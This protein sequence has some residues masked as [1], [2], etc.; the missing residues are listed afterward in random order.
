M[1]FLP[2]AT[3]VTS[4]VISPM[5]SPRRSSFT[6]MAYEFIDTIIFGDN[7]QAQKDLLLVWPI[8]KI[9][10]SLPCFLQSKYKDS[11]ERT[12]DNV[13]PE[14]RSN[15][16]RFIIL[17]YTSG[18]IPVTTK[19]PE[20]IA[21]LTE[22]IKLLNKEPQDAINP[23]KI[24]LISTTSEPKI[25]PG[26]S[27]DGMD[28]ILGINTISDKNKTTF[29]SPIKVAQE[30]TRQCAVIYN[31]ITAHEFATI[32]FEDQKT[33][34]CIHYT[35]LV[36]LFNTI[37]NWTT[38]TIL[39][40]NNDKTTI[41][42]EFINLT[43]EFAKLN[44]FHLTMAVIA[45]LNSS[46]I[47]RIPFLKAPRPA[48]ERYDK[49]YA[50]F[51]HNR[52]YAKYR[53]ILERVTNKSQVIPYMGVI[54]KDLLA[55]TS[56]E[57][58]YNV[59]KKEVNKITYDALIK[60]SKDYLVV[61]KYDI[62]K[63]MAVCAYLDNQQIETDENILYDLSLAIFPISHQESTQVID[64]LLKSNT[65]D[66]TKS[67]PSRRRSD[68]DLSGSD[69]IFRQ[70][71]LMASSASIVCLTQTTPAKP[72]IPANLTLPI[73]DT[74]KLITQASPNKIQ[75]KKISQWT[76][77]DTVKW[78]N[79]I[80]FGEHSSKFEKHKITGNILC[81]LTREDLADIG[82]NTVGDRLRFLQ[83]VRK[84]IKQEQD[85]KSKQH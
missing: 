9:P 74:R 61:K 66:W 43:E 2:T 84:L 27:L 17:A 40:T 14:L 45:G 4:P 22:F 73:L 35:K 1:T 34:K 78:L 10:K 50:D 52:N 80:S 25:T 48:I 67:T 11:K 64:E 72:L 79:I 12:D 59:E 69:K 31:K 32:G 13:T 26:K 24:L 21:Q 83:E 77:C 55:Y 5:I 56:K 53:E 70:S 63:N 76:V 82:V 51:S 6:T 20:S 37:A 33:K 81:D 44:N 30:L 18:Y 58:L 36:D 47:S 46:S 15:L 8:F 38:T 39:K 49:L 62:R 57:M 71:S 41:F 16:V 23:I 28:S 3:P 68:S 19:R 75:P 85:K 29:I 54:S 42:N 60:L 65:T 7:E